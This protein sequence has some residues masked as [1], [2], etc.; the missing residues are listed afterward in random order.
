MHKM[1]KIDFTCITGVE[2]KQMR[3]S[4]CCLCRV[5][6]GVTLVLSCNTF[7]SQNAVSAPVVDRTESVRWSFCMQISQ[8]TLSIYVGAPTWGERCR[9]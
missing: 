4:R 1:Q 3:G 2:V 6:P 8:L 7:K 5:G 9:E